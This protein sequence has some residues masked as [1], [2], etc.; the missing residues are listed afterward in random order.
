MGE[1]GISGGWLMVIII[2]VILFGGFGFGGNNAA[3]VGYATATDV[4]NAIN[5]AFA[6]QNAQNILLSSA[7]NNYE[8]ARLIDNQ[9]MNML[10]QNNTNLLAAIN[11]FNQVS[12]NIANGFSTVN[13]NIADLGYKM[14]SCCCGIKTMLLENRLQDTQLALQN[15]QNVAVNAEQ[16][17][18]L[19]SQMGQWTPYSA[20]T[21]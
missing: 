18:Y 16:S 21:A 3:A 12:S 5:T 7:N 9:S 2:L 6:N 20:T 15:A 4:T 19:L 10:S 11:G 14:E 8:T 13:A 17:Q 1:S